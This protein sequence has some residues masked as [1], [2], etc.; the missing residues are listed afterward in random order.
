MVSLQHVDVI[1]KQ[2]GEEKITALRDVTLEAKKGECIVLCGKSGCGKTT[3]T[4]LL[5]GLI[6]EFYEAEVTGEIRVNDENVLEH[7]IAELSHWVGS[8]F[9]NPK[10]QFFH[11]DTTSELAFGCENLGFEVPEIYQRMQEV[12]KMFSLEELLNRDIFALSGGEKQ[13]LACGS[14]VATMPK[15]IVLD[16]PTSNMDLYSIGKLA[17]IL[18][19]LKENGV[20][21]VISEHRLHFLDGIADRYYYM[22]NGAVESV[23]TRETLYQ[24]PRQER[25]QMGLRMLSF[26]ELV[27]KKKEK[28]T[29]T[30]ISL[31]LQKLEVSRNK[32]R[33]L[34]IG[35]VAFPYGGIVGVIGD[36]GVG[37]S[38]LLHTLLGFVKYRGKIRHGE[39]E[40]KR[41]KLV[42]DSFLV[43]QDVN[44]QMFADSVRN[45]VAVGMEQLQEEEIERLLSK[46]GLWELRAHHPATLS[47]GQKQR[48]AIVSALA[49]NK[50][51]LYF[52]EPTSGLDCWSMRRM[53]EML[54][55]MKQHVASI[56]IVTHDPELLAL[57]A[58]GILHLKEDSQ[59]EYVDLRD[60]GLKSML[61]YFSREYQKGITEI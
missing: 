17:Q 52:D 16:E 46:I 47:G 24:L 50:K 31:Y 10:T 26:D 34:Q 48:L 20:T 9:Q 21:I 33:I 3:I 49:S 15:V 5:N 35:E 53:S 8:V 44:C 19:R 1:Y 14:V 37:K 36:N 54:Q 7:T 42:E 11:L 59:Y 25:E 12:V 6:P 41:K 28:Q 51:Y 22:K 18:R 30:H 58:D 55:E 2:D 60:N 4:R 23:F 39:V 45:E 29:E 56:V 61:D 43:M 32:R 40:V 57:C 38:T 13:R 27:W